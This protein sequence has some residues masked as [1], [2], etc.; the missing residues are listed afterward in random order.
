MSY[1]HEAQGPGGRIWNLVSKTDPHHTKQVSRGPRK[2]TA[3]DAYYKVKRATELFGP[4]GQGWGWTVKKI[5]FFQDG[6]GVNVC[7]VTITLWWTEPSAPPSKGADVNP[8]DAAT[9]K[10]R[11]EFDAVG[12]NVVSQTVRGKDYIRLDDDCAKKALTDAIT[13]G[14]SYLG[15]SADVFFGAFDDN[16]YVQAAMREV[17]AAAQPAARPAQRPAAAPAAGE[18]QGPPKRADGMPAWL[19]DQVG[20]SGKFKDKTWEWM[21]QGGADGGRHLYLRWCFQNYKGERTLTRLAWMLAK[22][23]S[24]EEAANGTLVSGAQKAAQEEAEENR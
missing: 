4:V 23:Y 17:A 8:F 13:K 3:I 1:P 21:T 24:D 7:V 22:F 5:D 15:F 16:K 2:F 9:P 19:D 20:G 11:R 6:P 14:L 10:T 18:K 12:V